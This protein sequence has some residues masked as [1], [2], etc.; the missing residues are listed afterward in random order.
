MSRKAL[1]LIIVV[2]EET[3]RH[4]S[5]DVK[6]DL[7]RARAIKR[8]AVNS[9]NK[10]NMITKERERDKKRKKRKAYNSA[11]IADLAI[12]TKE[13][14][15][16]TLTYREIERKAPIADAGDLTTFRGRYS[17]ARFG[18]LRYDMLRD[19]DS[20]HNHSVHQWKCGIPNLS[21]THSNNSC[22]PENWIWAVGKLDWMLGAIAIAAMGRIS[23]QVFHGLL[24]K[25]CCKR[26]FDWVQIDF[27]EMHLRRITNLAA[28]LRRATAEKRLRVVAVSG[29]CSD[30]LRHRDGGDSKASRRKGEG[31]VQ[32]SSGVRL[33]SR[34]EIWGISFNEHMTNDVERGVGD[35]VE[36]TI[37]THGTRTLTSARTGVMTA[38]GFG[39]I[40]HHEG[41]R[42][43]AVEIPHSLK[44]LND[45][46]DTCITY[47]S[48]KFRGRLG[49]M[50]ILLG[51][52]SPSYD[53]R[54]LSSPK[55]P[56]DKVLKKEA[57]MSDTETDRP[58]GFS[59]N[60]INFI[61]SKHKRTQ[62]HNEKRYDIDCHTEK[63][64]EIDSYT[65]ASDLEKAAGLACKAGDVLL[66]T[67]CFFDSS[68]FS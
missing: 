11:A 52:Q 32:M 38:Y 54:K 56:C 12:V 43:V 27:K 2:E 53:T 45:T 36:T 21:C 40:N 41:S 13:R 4:Q 25:N 1:I 46:G 65:T 7:V 18:T 28:G 20:F 42:G 29:G 51:R 33:L 24:K 14:E 50:E 17:G 34:E 47:T 3:E 64:K 66:V 10:F 5:K 35:W 16:R 48:E 62:Q 60:H 44:I 30:S 58:I 8:N 68:P 26:W 55:N 49:E 23:K 39:Q 63:L 31:D 37:P 22:L 9:M 57:G 67:N 19:G 6:S 61:G 59:M 15:K